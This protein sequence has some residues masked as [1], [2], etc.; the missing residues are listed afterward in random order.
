VPKTLT[1]EQLEGRKEKAARFVENV[2]GDEDRADEI[3]E[4]SLESYAARRKLRILNPRCKTI[5]P[6]KKELQ[7][8]IRELEEENDQLQDALDSIAD[9]AAPEE[10]EEGEEG[11][12]AGED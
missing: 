3:R 12:D 5:M 7:D 1:R 10:E 6:S 2:L 9:I 8:R 11:E 4:E